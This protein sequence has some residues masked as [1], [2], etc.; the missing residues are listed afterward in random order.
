MRTPASVALAVVLAA[1]SAAATESA[2]TTI[3]DPAP[4]TTTAPTETTATTGSSLSLQ[5]GS[6][7]RFYIFELFRGEPLVVEAI[8]DDVEGAVEIDG[9]TALPGTFVIEAD[10]FVTE[11]GDAPAPL[12]GEIGW[13]DEAID[14]FILDVADYPEIIFEPDPVELTTESTELT[15]TLTVRDVSLPVTFSVDIEQTP[16]GYGVTGSA[17]VLRSDFGLRIPKVAHIAEVAD[18]LELQL[19]FYFGS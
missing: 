9:D 12:G 11:R 5:P 18:E 6:E 4:T 16:G 7:V 1:C 17:E 10:G 13:R 14:R 3:A 2:P 15:G 8:N 19:E